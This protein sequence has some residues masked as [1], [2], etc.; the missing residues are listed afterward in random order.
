MISDRL[1]ARLGW[2]IPSITFTL[3][4][5]IHHISGNSR[6]FPFFIS[7]SDYPGLERWIF[8][9]GLFVT[10]LIL[11]YVSFRLWKVH[12]EK[13]RR[14][15]MHTSLVCGM[16]VGGNVCAISIADM[17]DHPELHVA[18]ALNA[19]HFGIVWGVLAHLAV[20]SDNPIGK[21]LRVIAVSIALASIV[22]LTIIMNDAY[23][24]YPDALTPPLDLNVVQAWLDWA[25]PLEYLLVIGLFLSLAS[26][27]LDF[28]KNEEEEE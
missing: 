14:W 3:S 27:E 21:R 22:A 24:K 28:P 5:L 23:S 11:C 15:L 19:F 2:M 17:Y 9:T 8:T 4:M 13:S 26:F 7:E 12:L 16:W 25:A 10:G 20:K 6:N 1:I 18:T